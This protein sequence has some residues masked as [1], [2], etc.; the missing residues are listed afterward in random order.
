M[1][2]YLQS[3]KMKRLFTLLAFAASLICGTH[4]KANCNSNMNNITTDEKILFINGSPNAQGNTAA[5]AKVLLADKEYETLQLT[6]YRINVFGQT[7]EG[8]Q[9][10]EVLNKMKV[11]DVVVMGSPVYW[12]NIC[13]SMRTLLERFYGLIAPGTFKGKKLYFVYQGEAP[14][15]MMIDD[16]EYTMSRFAGM[17]GFTYKGMATNKEQAQ[18]L[19]EKLIKE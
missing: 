10:D 13:A 8:D 4:C 15:K 14:T 17:Y 7:L 19:H 9:L 1:N 2:T 11:A 5:L 16:G 3:K 12:H 6:N 18:Q